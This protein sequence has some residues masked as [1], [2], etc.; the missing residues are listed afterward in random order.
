M[1]D[2]RYLLTTIVAIFLALAIGLLIGSG[3]LADPI[4]EDL[5]RQVREKIQRNNE[6]QSR[7]N[8]YQ[9]RIRADEDFE[10][11]VEP[12]LVDR[13]LA[14]DEF[15]L[16]AFEGS[17]DALLDSIR[18][19]VDGAGGS[20]PTTITINNR[21]SM[22]DT[23]AAEE[24]RAA[25]PPPVGEEEDDVRVLVGRELG[26]RAASDAS[27][28][29]GDSLFDT[30][31]DP[32]IEHGY[33]DVEASDGDTIPFAADFIVAA[34]SPDDPPYDVDP[35]AE[36]LLTGLARHGAEVVATEGWESRWSFVPRIRDGDVRDLV[37]T[38]DHADTTAGRVSLIAELERL[39]AGDPGHY[40][41][42]SGSD[43]IAPDPLPG[44]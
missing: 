43:A 12:R 22:E 37:S 36:A 17:D 16:F 39:P 10:D 2:F 3:L 31:D 4:A 33:I 26:E 18:A 24:L 38:V 19:A 23:A 41:F 8:E 21:M 20:I 25:L 9:G 27:G 6:L 35:F 30:I 34:G 5:E 28:A 32:L 15:V 13:E 29:S 14:G 1:I 7:V 42:R 40:G 44:D 11:L